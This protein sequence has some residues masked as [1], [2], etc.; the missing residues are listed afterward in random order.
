MWFRVIWF[1]VVEPLMGLV[2][3][4]LVMVALVVFVL[5]MVKYFTQQ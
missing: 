4:V 2:T 3:W 5:A 1:R